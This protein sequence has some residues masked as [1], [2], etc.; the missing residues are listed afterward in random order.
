MKIAKQELLDIL[1]Q[2]N[3][4]E[5]KAEE[6]LEMLAEGLGDSILD[7]VK[8][9]ISKIEN[10]SFKAVGTMMFA[11][12]EPVARQAVDNIEIEL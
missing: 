7:I 2:N 3:I 11:A 6:I 8:L 4:N 9:A 1:S 5:D 12:V 10:E